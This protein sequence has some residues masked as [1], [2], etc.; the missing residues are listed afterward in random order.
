MSFSAVDSISVSNI[1]AASSTRTQTTT[2]T[3][4]DEL[5][6][7]VLGVLSMKDRAKVRTVFKKWNDLA[8]D[9]GTHLEPLFVD[10]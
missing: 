8:K 6:L 3:L 4:P 5:L 9:L 10:D 2:S 7:A 1:D